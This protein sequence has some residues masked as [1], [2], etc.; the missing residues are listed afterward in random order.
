MLTEDRR[1]LS[2]ANLAEEANEYR[3]AAESLADGLR[4]TGPHASAN[5]AY[6]RLTLGIFARLLQ[7]LATVVVEVGA[8]ETNSNTRGK[9][10]DASVVAAL[11]ALAGKAGEGVVTPLP[12]PIRH[13]RHAVR[14]YQ[15]QA[16]GVSGATADNIKA[17]TAARDAVLALT[18]EFG[19]ELPELVEN[20]E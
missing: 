2:T 5:P 3:T 6:L 12:E 15:K 17:V 16:E 10:L 11:Q 19:I 9:A 4:G 13:V 18:A 14:R 7:V 1:S 8:A 20:Q